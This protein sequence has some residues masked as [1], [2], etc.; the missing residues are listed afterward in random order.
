MAARLT[1]EA[2]TQ[3]V[4]D[5][6]AALPPTGRLYVGIDPGVHGALACLAGG[7]FIVLDLPTL[8]V[9]TSR[10]SSK[11]TRICRTEFDEAAIWDLIKPLRSVRDRVLVGLERGGPRPADTPTTAFRAGYGNGMWPLFF[12]SH[13]LPVQLVVPSV[14]KKRMELAGK[15]KNASRLLAMRLFPG[16]PVTAKA[17][18]DRAEALLLAY[19]VRRDN[20]R[21]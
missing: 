13:R 6:V 14:W 1:G 8:K 7:E 11:G 20:E 17:H 15:D 3:K 2:A 5:F 9:Q 21:A 18:A 4:V 19:Y 10:K 12:L 16:A